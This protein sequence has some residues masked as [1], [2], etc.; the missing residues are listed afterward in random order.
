MKAT[1]F[2]GDACNL[3]IRETA[4][5][6]CGNSSSDALTVRVDRT[7]PVVSCAVATNVLYPANNAMVNVGF[8][9]Q[10]KRRA[11]YMRAAGSDP[12]PDA[13]VERNASGAITRILLRVQRS[14][15]SPDGR[16]YRIRLTATDSCGLQ[17]YADCFVT[18]PRT[19]RGPGSAVKLPTDAL[20]PLDGDVGQRP[21][22][23]PARGWVTRTRE[24]AR[25]DC[26][27]GASSTRKLE[28]SGRTAQRAV[29]AT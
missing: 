5:D 22:G 21:R 12:A 16:V 9:Y 11:S 28:P 6:K 14:Q 2:S 24:V 20:S 27:G 7:T 10:A 8:T 18:V 15:T 4:S 25:L 19:N 1:T 26:P 17:S 29:R 23:A 3:E 13:V